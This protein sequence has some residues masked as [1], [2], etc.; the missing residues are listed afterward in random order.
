VGFAAAIVGRWSRP[1]F[2]PLVKL[3]FE[4]LLA[5]PASGCGD[6][7]VDREL[8]RHAGDHPFDGLIQMGVIA[9]QHR[10]PELLALGCLGPVPLEGLG[11]FRQLMLAGRVA[12]Q[13]GQARGEHRLE[14]VG[15]DRR[16][17]AALGVAVAPVAAAYV[18]SGEG[19]VFA[20]KAGVAVKRRAAPAALGDA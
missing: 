6:T 11:G 19:A 14:D 5:G 17:I 12:K 7:A 3:A 13:V 4:H 8:R 16:G 9:C 15:V 20:L 2:G 1:G 10:F 18:A